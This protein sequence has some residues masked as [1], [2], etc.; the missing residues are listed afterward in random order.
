M[1]AIRSELIA[2]ITKRALSALNYTEV[3]EKAANFE[4]LQILAKE[5]GVTRES[6]SAPPGWKPTKTGLHLCMAPLGKGW[7]TWVSEEGK[8]QFLEHGE[9]AIKKFS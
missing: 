6:G 9:G 8:A 1:D 4:I 5:E 3:E 2:D 7:S